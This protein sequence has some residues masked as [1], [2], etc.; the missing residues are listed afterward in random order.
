MRLAQ[1]GQGEGLISR[2]RCQT[3]ATDAKYDQTAHHP[4]D[5]GQAPVKDFAAWVPDAEWEGQQGQRRVIGRPVPCPRTEAGTSGI[6]NFRIILNL[7]R[8][9]GCTMLA[10]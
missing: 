7:D 4:G 2:T 9:V 10:A 6:H 8:P 1:A 3:A 5:F